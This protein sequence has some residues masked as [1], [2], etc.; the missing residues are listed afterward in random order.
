MNWYE[1]SMFARIMFI[2]GFLSSILI[3]SFI[4]GALG[5][6]I[7]IKLAERDA[8]RKS[9]SAEPVDGLNW[10]TYDSTGAKQR[11]KE[12]G[13]VIRRITCAG[14]RKTLANTNKPAP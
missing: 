8:R 7:D 10:L 4:L 3:F 11:V 5:C 9:K 13:K 12:Q 14:R 2:I 6:W 1:L